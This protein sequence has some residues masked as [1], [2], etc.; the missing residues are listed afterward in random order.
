MSPVFLRLEQA[1]L[2]DRHRVWPAER[3]APAVPSPCVGVCRMQPRP[4]AGADWCAGC[5]RTLDE[6]T[7]WSRMA[8][9][10]KLALWADLEQRCAA[11]PVA[12][13]AVE[14]LA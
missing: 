8:D 2:R 12:A 10:E 6:I 7:R 4:A 11:L 1:R 13:P 3:P 5:L 9:A 14:P